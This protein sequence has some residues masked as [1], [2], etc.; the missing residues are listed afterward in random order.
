MVSKIIACAAALLLAGNATAA[1][2]Q[3]KIKVGTLTCKGGEEIGLVLGSKA[4]YSCNYTPASGKPGQSYQATVTKIG[5]DI[6][7]TEGMVMVWTVLA[8]SDALNPKALAGNYYGATA[9]ASFGIGAGASVLVGGSDK[10]IVLQPVSVQG[11][12]GL[13][14]AVGVAELTLS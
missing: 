6:G 14:L 1:F 7:I 11:Q 10:T 3:A 5:L 4:T 2:A 9:D 12:T 13:N 8:S